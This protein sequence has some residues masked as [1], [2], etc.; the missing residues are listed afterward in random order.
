MTFIRSILFLVCFYLGSLSLIPLALLASYRG[1]DQVIRAS[2]HWAQWHRLCA[3]YILGVTSHI[4]GV[5]PQSPCIVA[6][7]HESFFEAIQL[8]AVFDRPVV[9]MK[10]ELIDLPLWGR[11]AAKHGSIPVDR[12][13]GS[14][15]LRAMLKASKAAI[16]EGRP[17]VI[18]PEGSRVPP[19]QSP[20]IKSGL[21]GLYKTLNLPIVP[22]AIDSGRYWPRNS[23]VRHPGIVTWR[24]G[25]P[26][27]AGLSRDEMESRV[28]AAINRLNGPAVPPS[29]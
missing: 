16:A 3:K 12:S 2:R 28:H 15:A 6:I 8:L 27:A 19:G 14:A 9:V 17:I 24:V 1:R 23:I 22:V 25:D 11:A 29:L 10:K 20:P 4:D 18:F 21:A 26:I 13:A 5:L 7:K